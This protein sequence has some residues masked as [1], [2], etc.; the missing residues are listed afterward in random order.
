MTIFCSWVYFVILVNG[1]MLTANSP[2]WAR[3]PSQFSLKQMPNP[4]NKPNA[5]RR[6]LFDTHLLKLKHWRE[7]HSRSL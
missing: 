4:D 6:R 7:Q 2:V 3:T 1:A 5:D